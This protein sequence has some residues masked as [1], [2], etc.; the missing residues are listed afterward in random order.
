MKNPKSA[1]DKY[2]LLILH[3][4]AD[5]GDRSPYEVFFDMPTLSHY[6]PRIN[7]EQLQ[8]RYSGKELG[9]AIT[10]RYINQIN[11]SPAMRKVVKQH[12]KKQKR[13]QS[14]SKKR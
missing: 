3:S 14:P 5:S 9:E 11:S 10:N 4:I 12:N 1:F 7:V 8:D 6:D 2:N 13:K